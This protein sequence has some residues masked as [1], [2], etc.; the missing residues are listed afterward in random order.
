LIYF[1]AKASTESDSNIILTTILRQYQT[2]WAHRIDFQT[3][4]GVPQALE[5]LEKSIVARCDPTGSLTYSFITGEPPR[6][7]KGIEGTYSKESINAGK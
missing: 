3:L 5:Q 2:G 4:G 6:L 7:E 1:E